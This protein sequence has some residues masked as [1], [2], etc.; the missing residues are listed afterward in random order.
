MNEWATITVDNKFIEQAIT[1]VMH[2][3]GELDE[4]EFVVV[5]EMEIDTETGYLNLVVEKRRV[6]VN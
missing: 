1:A 6:T 5:H 2:M 4:E 3:R